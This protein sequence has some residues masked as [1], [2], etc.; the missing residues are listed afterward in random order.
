MES[1]D[2]SNLLF[3]VWT[4]ASATRALL[5]DALTGSGLTAE[6]FALYSLLHIRGRTPTEL[7]R[8]LHLPATT[9]SSTLRRLDQR[10]HTRR[11]TDPDD[12]RS[13]RVEL[14]AAG[15]AAHRRA[16]KAFAPVLARVEEALGGSV[17][18]TRDR[19]LGIYEAVEVAGQPLQP[20]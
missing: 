8:A 14:S 12:R 7:A 9:M 20:V 17:A 19:L 13:S 10:G 5:N 16:G 6:E 3:D 15:R 2:S 18:D 4:L 11:R 1:G